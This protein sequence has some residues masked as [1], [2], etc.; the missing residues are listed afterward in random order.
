MSARD[1]L[2]RA[3]DAPARRA[4]LALAR[5]SIALGL[6]ERRPARTEEGAWPRVLWQPAATFVTLETEQGD[7]RGCRGV[8]EA[9]RPLPVDVAENAF[10]SAFD[11]PRF[12]PL[13]ARELATLRLS[14]SVLTPKEPLEVQSR[15]ALLAAVARGRDGL[16]VQAG[17]HRAT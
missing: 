15:R 17:R 11:D 16:L 1:D 2:E 10:A 3:L 7:L 9:C 13:E 14:I 6:A 5:T 4:L 12:S 8:L